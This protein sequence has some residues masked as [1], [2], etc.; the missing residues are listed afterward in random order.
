MK[1]LEDDDKKKMKELED[2]NGCVQSIR[3]ENSQI[4]ERLKQMQSLQNDLTRYVSQFVL[5]VTAVPGKIMNNR[6]S[7]HIMFSAWLHR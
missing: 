3:E 7:N 1:D 2:L 6:I 5:R 4:R